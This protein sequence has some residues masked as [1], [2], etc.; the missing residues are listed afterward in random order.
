MDLS[1]TRLMVAAP[2]YATLLHSG[3]PPERAAELALVEADI[4]IKAEREIR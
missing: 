1:E 2:L 4:L 3:T